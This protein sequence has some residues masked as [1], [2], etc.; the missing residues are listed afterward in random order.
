MDILALISF[1]FFIFYLSA[2]LAHSK[3]KEQ[4]DDP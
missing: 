4:E 3:K 2:A 1:V